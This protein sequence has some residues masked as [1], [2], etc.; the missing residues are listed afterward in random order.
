LKGQ[1]VVEVCQDGQLLDRALPTAQRHA[2]VHTR[3]RGF[4]R[5]VPHHHLVHHHGPLARA[6]KH[7]ILC[8]RPALAPREIESEGER[9][10]ERNGGAT[11]RAGGHTCREEEGAGEA[12][13]TPQHYLLSEILCALSLSLK[14]DFVSY[15]NFYKYYF[16]KYPHK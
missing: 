10:R 15:F 12:L 1:H 2:T 13:S 7:K 3:N 16:I 6:H 11:T 4:V 5:L 8:T 14:R 9:E